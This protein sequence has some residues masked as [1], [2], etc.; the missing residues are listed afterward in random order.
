MPPRALS[1]VLG[2]TRNPTVTGLVHRVLKT[3]IQT[4][5]HLIT[6]RHA[7]RVSPI[8]FLRLKAS[9]KS[10]VCAKRDFLWLAASS[11]AMCM[12]PGVSAYRAHQDCIS[13]KSARTNACCV[14]VENTTPFLPPFRSRA[15]YSA[16]PEKSQVLPEAGSASS[17]PKEST[18]IKKGKRNACRVRPIPVLNPAQTVCRRASALLVF[19][20]PQTHA[21]NALSVN[22]SRRLEMNRVVCVNRESIATA[23]EWRAAKV[24]ACIRFHRR[25]APRSR[26]ASASQP[27]STPLKRRFATCVRWAN[28]NTGW[29]E[30]VARNAQPAHSTLISEKNTSGRHARHVASAPFLTA[31]DEQ[32]ATAVSKA[33]FN[34]SKGKR[35]VLLVQSMLPPAQTN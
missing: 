17:A 12:Y 19:H 9:P 30:T 11:R 8:P 16:H 34:P 32:N 23:A 7:C 18:R 3:H 4:W 22:S 15:V 6:G 29:E 33:P 21:V 2:N 27:M 26:R 10:I 35:S 5:W 31:L 20:L 25:G 24:A 28:L 13:Q 1:A 14:Q